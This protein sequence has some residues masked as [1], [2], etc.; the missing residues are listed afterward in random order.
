MP[1]HDTKRKNKNAD[2]SRRVERGV[3]T[4]TTEANAVADPQHAIDFEVFIMS[5]LF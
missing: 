1:G 2:S 5:V 4:V 3:E